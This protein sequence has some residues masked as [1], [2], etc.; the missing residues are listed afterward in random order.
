MAQYSNYVLKL[1]MMHVLV[2]H[3]N[4][5]ANIASSQSWSST[6]LSLVDYNE[7]SLCQ[8]SY[9]TDET[10]GPTRLLLELSLMRKHT[11]EHTHTHTHTHRTEPLPALSGFASL[12][13]GKVSQLH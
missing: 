4:Y 3:R 6:K 1:E 10:Y 11:C 2:Q 12:L 9:N 13:R 7:F 8:P 5:K